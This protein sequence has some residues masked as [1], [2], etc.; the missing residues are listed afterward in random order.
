MEAAVATPHES[1]LVLIL[2]DDVVITA[3]L[4]EG[5]ERE[6]RTVVTCNDL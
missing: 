4:A 2:D 6:G 3:A 1:Q 5:L